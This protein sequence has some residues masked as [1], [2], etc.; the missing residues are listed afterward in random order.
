VG[1]PLSRS[2]SAV[3]TTL[4]GRSDAS[5]LADLSAVTG[6]HANTLREH[7]E[8]LLHHGLVRRQRSEPSGRGRP[9][10]LYRATS[11]GQPESEYA[12]LAATLASVLRRTSSSPRAEAIAAGMQWGHALARERGAS[13][14]LD[15]LA[16]RRRVTELLADLRFGPEAD[17]DHTV[18]ILTTCPLL[19]AA[20]SDPDVVC[21]VH[22]GVVRGALEELAA[23]PAGSELF[24]FAEPGACRLQLAGAAQ[25]R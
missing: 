22:L 1:R 19:E 9:A 24:P 7:L 6:L 10:R 12:G 23:D 15:A 5:T 20:R 2:R 11:A 16:A 4:E 13:T 21:G 17:A 8:A 14:P 25:R 18:L 3:L